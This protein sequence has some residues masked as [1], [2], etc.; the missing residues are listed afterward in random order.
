MRLSLVLLLLK[1]LQ[2]A[3]TYYRNMIGMCSLSL[4]ELL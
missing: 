3:D 4:P 1:L 2:I